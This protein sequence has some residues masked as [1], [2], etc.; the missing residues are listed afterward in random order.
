MIGEQKSLLSQPMRSGKVV[1]PGKFACIRASFDVNGGR[2][3]SK[4]IYIFVSTHGV[5]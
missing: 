2:I 5:A 3:F 4:N 1:A